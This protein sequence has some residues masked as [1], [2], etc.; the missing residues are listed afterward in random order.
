MNLLELKNLHVNYGAICALK[1]VSFAVPQGSIVALLGSNGAGKSTVLRTIS[2]LLPATQ[3]EILFQNCS[4]AKTAAHDIVAKGICH[5]PEGRGI[6]L[7]L[8]VL[9]NLDLG[10]WTQKNK[11]LYK[12]NLEKVFALFPR[13]KER[14]QQLSGT[15]SGGEL[16]M[17]AIGRALM[18]A[19]KLLL[20]DEPSLGLAPKLIELIFSIIQEIHK[21][22]MTIV[23]VE[24]NAH[25]AL[26]I[27]DYGIVLETGKVAHHGKAADLLNSSVIQEAY[28]G[29]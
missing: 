3:G 2:G 7:N 20:L 14:Q 26:K 19:P 9:E 27:A 23:L 22:G 21:Q 16:Q 1:G 29:A 28:L 11:S 4:L 13:L 6:F 15:L 25:Q 17:L 10:A 12:S 5:V 18:S 24:Q 8:S